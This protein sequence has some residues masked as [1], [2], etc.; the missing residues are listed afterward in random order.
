MRSTARWTVG[1]TSFHPNVEVQ[2]R[3][4]AADRGLPNH[5]PAPTVRLG[6][7]ITSESL[8]YAVYQAV[9]KFKDVG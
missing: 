2:A 1:R 3:V 7:A 6:R 5:G 9:L 8:P 4:T